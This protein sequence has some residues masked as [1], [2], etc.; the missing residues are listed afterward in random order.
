[1][2][3]YIRTTDFTTAVASLLS[4]MKML[5]PS[6]E[7][8]REKEFEIWHK[9]AVLPT[10]ASS[11]YGLALYA[12]QEGF[13]PRIVVENKEYTFPDYR[14]YKYT[15]TDIEHAEFSSNIL[16]QKALNNGITIDEK[17][18]QFEDIIKELKNHKILLLRI[19]AKPIRHSKR[20]STKFI[21]VHGFDGKYFQIVDPALGG[22]SI[23]KEVMKESFE[24]L[25]TKKHKDHRMIIFE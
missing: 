10:R 25:E 12:K 11:I 1:M 19:N 9:T 16:L 6:I 8:S 17:E 23:P 22:L 21:V 18:I 5:N 7:Y 24:S 15:K 14:F 3:P 4:A 2:T 13:S 20:N